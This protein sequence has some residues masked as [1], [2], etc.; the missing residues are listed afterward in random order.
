MAPPHI[1]VRDQERRSGHRGGL[2][3]LVLG[4][5]L[6][7]PPRGAQ[8]RAAARAVP[9]AWAAVQDSPLAA[10]SSL[11]T[12]LHTPH[13]PPACRH[14]VTIDG[15]EDVPP[16]DGAALK[17][18]IAGQ[19]VRCCKGAWGGKQGGPVGRVAPFACGALPGARELLPLLT[20]ATTR[21]MLPPLQRGCVRQLQHAALL[22]RHHHRGRLLHPAQPRRAGCG[23]RRAQ[24]P[25]SFPP[26]A[27]T[28]SLP[29]CGGLGLGIAVR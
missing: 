6:P 5:A 17:K 25:A 7:A 29:G 16:N 26:C 2:P 9:C 21:P 3:L 18:A 1:A 12:T 28:G 20:S 4:P 15:F 27:C 8:V 13:L 10:H 22:L 14:V 23:V 11:Q 19:P 24:P